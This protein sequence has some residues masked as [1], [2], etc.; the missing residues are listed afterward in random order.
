MYAQIPNQFMKATIV[1]ILVVAF[2]FDTMA[3]TKHVSKWIVGNYLLDFST[4][5]VT[6][7]ELEPPYD[8]ENKRKEMYIDAD[9]AI[10]LVVVGATLY[11]SKGNKI[12]YEEEQ[13][14]SFSHLIPMP[15][16]DNIICCMEDG[17]LCKID[18]DKNEIISVEK[19]AVFQNFQAVH[20]ADCSG[21]W[22]IQHDGKS[23][24]RQ[25]LTS[26]GVIQAHNTPL[27]NN[28]FPKELGWKLSWN[29]KYYTG[30]DRIGTNY[31]ND[32]IYFGLFNKR[33]AT[34][35]LTATHTFEGKTVIASAF[36]P[37]NS[38]VYYAVRKNHEVEIVEIP[39]VNDTP[40][41]ENVKEICQFSLKAPL[42]LTMHFG[43]DGR[44]YIFDK[45]NIGVVE[46]DNNGHSSFTKNILTLNT[47][48]PALSWFSYL[49][50][51]YSDDYCN[52][53]PCPEMPA[54]KII[55]ED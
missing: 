35:K 40:D 14:P 47:N 42:L 38:K 15:N 34:F 48:T 36:S 39:I 17:T 6:F 54:P 51:W 18:I 30:C 43:I 46:F 33:T 8:T 50:D 24:N 44:L 22:L 13:T 4:N 20:N 5:P 21:I 32:G 23:I 2:A 26:N 9:G 11:D 10:R 49:Y 41:F 55:M 29:C 16:N 31:Q 52:N 25:L 28:D 1:L 45:K 3:Q 19:N 12:Q 37:D 7:K 27:S 53:T